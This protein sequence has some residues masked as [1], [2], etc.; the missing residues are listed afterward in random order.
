MGATDI[1]VDGRKPYYCYRVFV[2]G[3]RVQL[4]KLKLNG[5]TLLRLSSLRE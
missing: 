5:S 4:D 2:T 1:I 3:P